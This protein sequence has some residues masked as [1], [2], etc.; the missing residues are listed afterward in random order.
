MTMTSVETLI[1]RWNH[2][3]RI[4]EQHETVWDDLGILFAPYT[5]E[6]TTDAETSDAN[7][8]DSRIQSV[9]D[10]TGVRAAN[11]FANFLRSSIFPSTTAWLKLETDPDLMEDFNVRDALDKTEVRALRALADSNF[12]KESAR[13][14][15]N[16][17]VYGNSGFSVKAAPPMVKS[18]GST[19]NGMAFETIPCWRMW[20]DEGDSGRI[21]FYVRQLDLPAIELVKMLKNPGQAVIDCL[22]KGALYKRVRVLQFVYPNEGGV[23]NGVRFD[24]KPW[25]SV[26]IEPVHKEVL[27]HEGFERQPYFFTRWE[28]SDHDVYGF[29]PG[30][31]ARPDAM[32]NQEIMAQEYDALGRDMNPTL[33]VGAEDDM[34]LDL[35]V[36]G[37]ITARRPSVNPEYLNTNSR[38]DVA[39]QIRRNNEMSIN[40][41][42]FVD[43]LEDPD[44]QPRSAEESRRLRDRATLALGGPADAITSEFLGPVVE[45]LILTME[46]RGAL[47]ELTAINQDLGGIALRPAFMSP[48]FA[49]QKRQIFESA[50][51]WLNTKIERASVTGDPKWTDDV[52][53][54]A[55]GMLE[56]KLLDFPARVRHTPEEMEEKRQ[57]RAAQAARQQMAELQGGGLSAP[58]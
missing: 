51:E 46:A 36:N 44:T 24:E 4:R 11:R 40:R 48:F 2:M 42:F 49:A 14:L 58:A 30:H 33:I 27:E 12:Y 6:V 39:E 5:G 55:F 52:D 18:D 35:G 56:E 20:I 1:K 53:V 41:A 29:G 19:F 23:R 57:A 15:R 31:Q 8:G 34:D 21:I 7:F 47:P 16:L 50:Q 26:W 9:L 38:Y 3:R 28:V 54:E 37:H 13:F 43:A 45:S 32:C 22:D 17:P 25:Q 10:G